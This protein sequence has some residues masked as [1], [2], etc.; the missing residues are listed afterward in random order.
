MR[1]LY[2]FEVAFVHSP[3]PTQSPFRV[4]SVNCF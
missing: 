4:Y 2:P 1:Q 3:S